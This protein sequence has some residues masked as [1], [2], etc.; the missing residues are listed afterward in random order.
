MRI[1]VH[2]IA[3]HGAKSRV[4]TQIR[5]GLQLLDSQGEAVT[6]W[7]HLRLPEHAVVKDRNRNRQGQIIESP[8]TPP[9]HQVLTMEATVICASNP[10]KKVEVCLGCIRREYKR[11][12]RRKENR[13]RAFTSNSTTPAQS[14]PG[15]PT[16]D[17]SHTMET[18][19]DEDRIALERNRT[20]IFNCVDLVDF[21][22]GEVYLPARITCYCRHHAEKVGFCIYLTAKDHLGNIVA[23][24]IS[25]PIMITDDHKS[26]KFKSDRKRPKAEYDLEGR[27][28]HKHAE[29]TNLGHDASRVTR[30]STVNS[31][32]TLQPLRDHTSAAAAAA[33]A[34]LPGS[35]LALSGYPSLATTPLGGNTPLPSPLLAAQ[36]SP[37]TTPHFPPN[38]LALSSPGFPPSGSPPYHMA[39]LMPPPPPPH[40]D[41]LGHPYA[42]IA[43]TSFS[44]FVSSGQDAFLG[45][46][47]TSPVPDFSLL[48][49]GPVAITQVLHSSQSTSPQSTVFGQPFSPPRDPTVPRIDRMVPAEGPV[50]GG[51]EVTLLGTGFHENLQVLFGSAP[52]K[53][54]HFWSS[55]T[56]VCVL[57]PSA[58][59]GPVLVSF[60]DAPGPPTPVTPEFGV[61]VKDPPAVFN[62]VDDSERQLMELAL[63]VVGIKMTGQV[64]D[65]RQV[66]M[67]IMANENGSGLPR[68]GG[69]AGSNGGGSHHPTSTDINGPVEQ[70]VK[71]F[72]TSPQH[73]RLWQSMHGA[74]QTR[75]LVALE[76]AVLAVLAILPTVHAPLD[77]QVLTVLHERT[78]LTLLHVAALLG[79]ARLCQFL[80]SHGP[81]VD[82]QDDNGMTALHFA[83]WAGHADVARL[84]LEAGASHTR[85][86]CQTK[87]PIDL[88]SARGLNDVVLLLEQRE[89]YMNFLCDGEDDVGGLSTG[90]DMDF[91]A[92]DADVS[93]TDARTIDSSCTSLDIPLATPASL[94]SSATS[95][96]T[97]SDATPLFAFASRVLEKIH[98]DQGI[99]QQRLATGR[100]FGKGKGR[101][102][103]L[104]YPFNQPGDSDATCFEGSRPAHS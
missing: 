81:S 21:H 90:L 10:T 41:R 94:S 65:P 8:P 51:P 28:P 66:A 95:L 54:T 98:W 35:L 102:L 58:V 11:A 79:M 71:F 45:A 52:A 37:P 100:P 87:R 26:T 92:H 49:D 30:R 42:G 86:T 20:I 1:E 72:H 22:K 89:D 14:R 3:Q 24:G 5:L 91:L 19:W 82:L 101:P 68:R 4:E 74:V 33:A 67:R 104:H 57:P 18:D 39:G 75:N 96:K 64:E 83:A 78:N 59:S 17:H 43:L 47:H 34:H 38:F 36:L 73:L 76:E 88:A 48:N 60:A 77:E 9:R 27:L 69:Q 7:P 16:G 2:G 13:H 44:P 6:Y 97:L 31:P 15:S 25:P 80:L 55:T 70:V 56:M 50:S 29:P 53:I 63:Q 23:T 46:A 85:V 62:Y 84:L 12:Q 99:R 61:E 103:T 32:A 93:D 40:S